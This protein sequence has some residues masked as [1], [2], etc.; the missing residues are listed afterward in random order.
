MKI[1]IVSQFSLYA[2]LKKGNRPSFVKSCDYINAEKFYH[3]FVELVKKDFCG[4]VQQGVFGADM[5]I[6]LINDGP[7]TFFIDTKNKE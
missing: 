3:D 1:L 6:I 4:V 5:K 2:L 7:L